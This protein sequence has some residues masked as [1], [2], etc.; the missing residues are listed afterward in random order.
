MNR[1]SIN[2]TLVSL[3]LFI[4]VGLFDIVTIY[5]K[6]CLWYLGCDRQR[7]CK[8]KLLICK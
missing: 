3:V 6:H 7:E 5:Y 2:W 4:V 1:V 8:Q